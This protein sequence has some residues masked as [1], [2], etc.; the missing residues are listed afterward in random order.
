MTSLPVF[1]QTFDYPL[2]NSKLNSQI[3]NPTSSLRRRGRRQ[4]PSCGTICLHFCRF[5][6]SQKRVCP[7]IPS[8]RVPMNI[9]KIHKENLV[10]IKQQ[11]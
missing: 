2:F 1:S 6:E 3:V 7:G 5:L 4:N 10:Q 11:S 9:V 8:P